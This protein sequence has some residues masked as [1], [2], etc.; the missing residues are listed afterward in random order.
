MK[1]LFGIVISLLVLWVSI[2]PSDALAASSASVTSNNTSFEDKKL[3]GENFT[4]H[5]LQEAQFTN[6]DLSSTNF[7]GVN[8]IG[9]VFNGALLEKSNLHG[10]DLSYA[11]SYVSSFNH[12][13]LT[14]AILVGSILKR[15]TFAEADITGAD[16]TDASLD[17]S[18]L[19][20]LCKVA[21][22]VNSKTGI[23]TKD[24]LECS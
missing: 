23:S 1:T 13:N 17:Q 11:I 6:V 4:G 15:T 2:I 9:S 21:S 3:I 22:G 7:S 16:F 8:L 18:E 14:D 5:S 19:K 20:R 24:S 12:A 10:A